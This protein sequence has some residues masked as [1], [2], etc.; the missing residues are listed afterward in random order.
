MIGKIIGG[1]VGAQAAEHTSKVGGAGGA[2]LGAASV[3]LLRRMSIPAMLA[4]GAGGYAFKKWNDKRKAQDAKRKDF[5]T[6][7]KTSTAAA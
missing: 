3:A 7:P 1:I 4:I 2:V 6:P 5:E